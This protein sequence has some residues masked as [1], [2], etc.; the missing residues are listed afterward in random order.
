MNPW[1]PT[2]VEWI[3][4][5]ALI[6][7]LVFALNYL[8]FDERVF[9]DYKVWLFSFP[10]I[11]LISLISWYTHIVTMHWYRLQYPKLKETPKRLLLVS[12]THVLMTSAT[13]AI[14]F[15]GYDS[16]HFLGYRLDT[17]QYKLSILMAIG[18]TLVATTLWEAEYVWGEWKKTMAE[19]QTLEQLAVRQEFETLKN[20]VN[21]H[22]LFN[23]FNTLSSLINEDSSK[24]EAFLNE[25][26]KVYRYLLRNNE[27]GLSTLE[28][29]LRFI[30][31]YYV[32][33]NTRYGD[34]IQ[35]QVETDPTYGGYLLPSLS[36]QLLVENA[37]KHNVVSKQQ[38]LVIDIF[39]TAGN[40]LAVNNNLQCKMVKAPSA[41]IGLENIRSKYE[42]LNEEGFQVLD[43][44]RNF[45]V[46][47]P[48]LWNNHSEKRITQLQQINGIYSGQF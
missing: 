8:L 25:L 12:V 30:Q 44:E 20:Q 1:K 11:I 26:S 6:P 28:N 45:T 29:E 43:D 9:D 16:F 40:K 10:I 18:L 13:F 14:M 19:K 21:P 5:F 38:P 39:T 27:D 4:F 22:F 41:G 32:L 3:S 24:A 23:C 33:L 48:L 42:L 46:V 7:F 47:L 34:A 36:L 35:L 37:V 31:S 2:R 15:F 17:D